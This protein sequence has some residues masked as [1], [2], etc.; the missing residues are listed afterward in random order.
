MVTGAHM[1]PRPK[2][3]NLPDTYLA[4]TDFTDQSNLKN[5]QKQN[6]WVSQGLWTPLVFLSEDDCQFYEL[7]NKGIPVGAIIYLKDRSK[8]ETYTS[9]F[10]LPEY[11]NNG[12]AKELYGMTL[13]KYKGKKV[14]AYINKENDLGIKLHESAG[15]KKEQY[16]EPSGKFVYV[17][18]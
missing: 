3:V 6:W 14:R 1:P 10:I 13:P 7:K 16:N 9:I 17:W 15:F 11:R 12:F 18:S 5:I 4:F 2:K 8:T